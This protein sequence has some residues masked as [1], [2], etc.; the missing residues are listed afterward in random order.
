MD[1]SMP[2]FPVLHQ[3]LELAQTH[4]HWVGDVIQPSQPLSSPFPPAFNL[5]QHQGLFQGVSSSQ[6][7]GVSASTSVLPMNIQDWSPLGWTGWISVQ[8]RGFSRILQCSAFFMVQHSHP[9]MTTGKTVAWTMQTFG[10]KVMSLLFNML[11]RLVIAFLPWSKSLLISWL[12]SM[13]AVILEPPKIKV[14]HCFHC[15]PIYLPWSD[16]ARC[17]DLSFLNLEY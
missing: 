1:C 14:S 7:I 5:S 11:S 16:G 15:F 4:V 10:G 2:G 6:S 13:P 12:Q 9:Y 3:L 17:H 8:S